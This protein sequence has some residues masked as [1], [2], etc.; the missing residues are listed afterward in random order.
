MIAPLSAYPFFL[1]KGTEASQ[2]GLIQVFSSVFFD[3]EILSIYLHFVY[4]RPWSIRPIH[5]YFARVAGSH[6]VECFLKITDVESMGN[7]G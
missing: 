6:H 1:E 3:S 5:N 4:C 7:D 2:F